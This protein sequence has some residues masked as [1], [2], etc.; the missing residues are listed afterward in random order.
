MS[1]GGPHSDY[2]NYKA[3]YHKYLDKPL[4]YRI[5]APEGEVPVNGWPVMIWGGGNAVGRKLAWINETSN[6]VDMRFYIT[7]GSGA[8]WPVEQWFIQP[9]ANL[10]SMVY[11]VPEIVDWNGWLN[12]AQQSAITEHPEVSLH[13]GVLWGSWSKAL[14]DLLQKLIAGTVTPYTTNTFSQQA[15][16]TYPLVDSNRIYLGGFS[17]GAI[18]TFAVL[19][20]L[21]DMIAAV[22][23]CAA[24]VIGTAYVNHWDAGSDDYNQFIVDRLNYLAALWC[25]IPIFIYCATGN[26]MF[27]SNQALATAM[28]TACSDYSK[29][30][31]LLFGK[32]IGG[33]HNFATECAACFIDTNKLNIDVHTEQVFGETGANPAE[34]LLSQTLD[35]GRQ[36]LDIDDAVVKGDMD[37]LPYSWIG[38]ADSSTDFSWVANFRNEYDASKDILF[39]NFKNPYKIVDDI[40]GGKKITLTGSDDISMLEDGSFARLNDYRFKYV[41]ET[42]IEVWQPK[43][44]LARV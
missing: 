11:I 15:D 9:F 23:A 13:T 30:N 8:Y 42:K 3:F 44:Y 18:S 34:W 6:N 27:A 37:N 16:Y 7:G 43:R 41:T 1:Y 33:S 20:E 35:D 28:A 2:L 14:K 24:Q 38:S 29:D 39:G 19:T 40:S 21:K 12:E 5:F 22:F 17:G 26:A 10:E 36:A 25:H 4:G 32:Y 31:R